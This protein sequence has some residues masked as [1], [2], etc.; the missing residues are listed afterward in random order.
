MASINEIIKR[1]SAMSGK[2]RQSQVYNTREDIKCLA[3]IIANDPSMWSKFYDYVATKKKKE[4][5]AK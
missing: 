4:K 2:K 5:A 3:V 1:V